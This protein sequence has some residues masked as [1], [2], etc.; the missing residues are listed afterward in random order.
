MIDS[1]ELLT[2]LGIGPAVL[3]DQVEFAGMC[4]FGSRIW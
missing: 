1:L 2:G 4:V 3:P